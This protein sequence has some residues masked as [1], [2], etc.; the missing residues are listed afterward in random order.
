[1]RLLNHLTIVTLLLLPASA[2]SRSSAWE[3]R[4][5]V[6]AKELSYSQAIE[7]YSN[8]L[9]EMPSVSAYLKLA[10]AYYFGSFLKP[11]NQREPELLKAKKA[12]AEVRARKAIDAELLSRDAMVDGQMALYRSGKEKIRLGH[13]VKEQAEAALKLDPVN[14]RAH[15]VMGVWHY[16]VENLSGI[17]RFFGN[18]FFGDVPEGSLE[19]SKRHLEA[20]AKQD[21]TAI[22]FRLSLA[23]TLVA[24]DEEASA[25]KELVKAL[26]L[27]LRVGSDVE[28]KK[29]A[30][31]LL[32][33]IE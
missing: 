19:E 5:D 16:E 23:K 11:E 8:A 10:D 14:A 33:E 4:G 7:D 25:R 31:E 9:K 1:M 18:L 24:L 3:R 28:N 17:E 12:L 26:E 29:A 20:A 27:P 21:P 32:E 6:A 15:A 2:F 22:F 30:Q 13:G